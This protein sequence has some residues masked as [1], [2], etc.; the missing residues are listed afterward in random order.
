MTAKITTLGAILTELYVPDRAGQTTNVVLGFDNLAAYLKGH[1]AFGSTIGRFANRIARGRFS[2]DGVEYVLAT[3]NGRNHLH[4]GP[5]GFHKKVWQA[6][7]VDNASGSKVIFSYFS[8]DGEEGYPGNLVVSATYSLTDQ[9]ELRIDYL[10]MTDK[11][12]PVNLTNHSYF[13]LSGSGDILNHE[14]KLETDC[15]TPSD[16]ELIPTGEIRS[17]KGTPLDFISYHKIGERIEQLKP[18]PNGYDHNYVL[19]SDGKS[20]ALAATVF[21]PQSGRVLETFTTEP[22]VQLYTA[23]WL[24]GSLIGPGGI[25]YKQHAGFCLETQHYPDS[26]NKPGFPSTVLRPGTVFYSTTVYK[27]SNR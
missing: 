4:G 25:V 17:V 8:K 11:A 3:N 19:K 18:S 13:N 16:E 21:D 9:N 10:A 23:N 15:Y 7:R 20:L 14:L 22:G 5:E 6:Q 26:I 2:L 1:P 24:D 27:F 12:T